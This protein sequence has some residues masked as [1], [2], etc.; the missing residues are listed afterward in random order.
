MCKI[1]FNTI[2]VIWLTLSSFGTA[3][4][5]LAG[6]VNGDN[7]VDA[8]DYF[9]LRDNA[10]DK[11]Y[12]LPKSDLNQD[13]EFNIADIVM[14]E[15]YLY[16]EGKKPGPA[17]A[18]SIVSKTR[19]RIGKVDQA[20]GT[21][22]ILIKN[23]EGIG[24]FEFALT[25]TDAILE[26]ITKD[27]RARDFKFEI[28]ERSII[29]LQAKG[30][31][32]DAGEGLLIT[33]KISDLQ[34]TELCLENVVVASPFGEDLRLG[35]G[36]CADELFT[37]QGYE[38]LKGFAAIS[39]K[40]IRNFDYNED[41][42]LDIRDV[43]AVQNILF[44]HGEQP[45]YRKALNQRS[46]IKLFFDN[47]DKEAK[48]LDVVMHNS[49]PVAAFQFEL[50]GVGDLTYLA[51]VGDSSETEVVSNGNK[52]VGFSNE[53]SIIEEGKWVLTT[54]EY[55]QAI[56]LDVCIREPLFADVA[57][58]RIPGYTKGCYELTKRVF[59]CTDKRALNYNPSANTEDGSCAF[60]KGMKVKYARRTF[61]EKLKRRYRERK[62][63]F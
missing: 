57:G 10:F 61:W 6:D 33:L 55:S 19:L 50:T 3:A 44:R 43:Q 23:P 12:K 17:L 30:Y 37:K 11:K 7:L 40:P 49:I 41:K 18:F 24:G 1:R 28:K 9:L 46:R 13:K 20:A 8:T 31:P 35:I 15:D 53:Q 5:Q 62:Y 45:D 48:T 60:P 14:M 32:I 52:V 59:G 27:S 22:D 42:V 34:L 29:G 47:V 54:L 2:V 26:V 25:G 38:T 39:S 4:G 58:N 36:K 63:K 16:R 56:G 51:G 21:V